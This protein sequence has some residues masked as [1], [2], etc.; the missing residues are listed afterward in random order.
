MKLLRIV[1]T[2]LI[3]QVKNLGAPHF[4]QIHSFTLKVLKY[5]NQSIKKSCKVD[6]I[7]VQEMVKKE[8]SNK[9]KKNERS[10]SQTKAKS[11]TEG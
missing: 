4:S 2:L 5:L 9:R 11:V 10:A 1:E 6:C 7:V 8:E 3:N